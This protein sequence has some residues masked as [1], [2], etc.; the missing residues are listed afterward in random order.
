MSMDP[1]RD[2][3]IIQE[4]A[5]DARNAELERVIR[6]A[7]HLAVFLKRWFHDNDVTVADVAQELAFYEAAREALTGEE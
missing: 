2:H 4:R 1:D 5:K 3:E 6:S 7:D